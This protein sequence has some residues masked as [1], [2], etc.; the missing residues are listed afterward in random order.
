MH[1]VAAMVTEVERRPEPGRALEQIVVINAAVPVDL[2]E[3][4]SPR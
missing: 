3:D 1:Q 4:R 2:A